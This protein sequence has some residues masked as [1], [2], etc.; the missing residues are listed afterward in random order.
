MAG[1]QFPRIRHEWRGQVLEDLLGGI[2]GA[3]TGIWVFSDFSEAQGAGLF[4]GAFTAAVVGA[5]VLVRLIRVFR[6]PHR[7]PVATK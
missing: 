4:T 2:L 7:P 3:S 5:C 6:D 1:G